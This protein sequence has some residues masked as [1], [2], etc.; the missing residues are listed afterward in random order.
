[1]P[2]ESIA[3]CWRPHQL[4]NINHLTAMFSLYVLV[5][6]WVIGRIMYGYGYANGGPKGRMA[7]GLVSHLG[8]LPLIFMT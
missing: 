7:G 2:P 5:Q 1:M 4:N 6:I 8:D 3:S